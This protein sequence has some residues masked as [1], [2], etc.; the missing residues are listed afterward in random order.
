M[1]NSTKAGGG[2]MDINECSGETDGQRDIAEP[3]RAAHPDF[4]VQMNIR[5]NCTEGCMA[6][7]MTPREDRD[8]GENKEPG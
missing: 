2:G 6:T 4:P 5:S 8:Q 3:S 7:T 1:E